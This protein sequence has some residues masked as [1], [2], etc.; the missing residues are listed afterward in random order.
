MPRAIEPEIIF[1]GSENTLTS[2]SWNCVE[3]EAVP[4]I[5]QKTRKKEY[6][7]WGQSGKLGFAN[8]GSGSIAS[9][10]ASEVGRAS[11]K[12]TGCKPWEGLRL[13]SGETGYGLSEQP[14]A[15]NR[16]SK[17]TPRPL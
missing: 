3:S 6:S 15:V 4:W 13:N 11:F 8:K 9:P 17:A 2:L 14:L 16:G 5:K 12:K 10:E 7:L 1:V